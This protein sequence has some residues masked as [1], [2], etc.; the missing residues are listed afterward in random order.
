MSQ[1]QL[2]SLS[3]D[4][5]KSSRVAQDSRAPD[6]SESTSTTSLD[7]Y[8]QPQ[9]QVFSVGQLWCPRSHFSI[10]AISRLVSIVQ[11]LSS[12]F[13]PPVSALSSI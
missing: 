6:G 1:E 7:P 11:F 12:S 13:H 2:C 4:I 5:Q 9:L 8:Q 3:G 10:L